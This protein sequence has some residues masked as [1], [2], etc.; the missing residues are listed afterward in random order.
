MNGRSEIRQIA[1]EIVAEA[2]P[3]S[4]NYL[5]ERLR[6]EFGVSRADANRVLLELRR[7]RELRTSMGQ[8]VLPGHGSGVIGAVQ[9]VILTV[10][11]LAIGAFIAW[12]IYSMVNDDTD[13]PPMPGVGS[14]IVVPRIG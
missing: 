4:P 10:V 6:G 3:C 8:L 2:Q 9:T 14:T 12:V 7:D 5:V 13:M 11:V 1:L